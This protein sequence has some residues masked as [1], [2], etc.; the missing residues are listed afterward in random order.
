MAKNLVQ[1]GLI[2]RATAPYVRTSGQG[3]LIG[4]GLFGVALTDIA[5][6]AIGDWALTGVWDITKAAGAWTEGNPVYWDNSA[7]VATQTPAASAVRIGIAVLGAGDIIAASGDAT[8]RVRLDGVNAVT[9]I[10]GVGSGYKIARG[11]LTT[12]TASDTVVTGLATVVAAVA[13]LDSDPVAGAQS[14]TCSIGDQAGAP[15]AGSI[16]VKTWKATSATDTALIAASTF[17]K[18]VNWI[19]IGT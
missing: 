13:S 16:L 10:V 2:L 6:G 14:C 12:A 3:A 9:G 19:A 17:S 18:K 5:S 7:K 11:Q 1:N 4:A 8:G 15:A